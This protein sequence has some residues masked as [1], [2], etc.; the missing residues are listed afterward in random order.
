MSTT[1]VKGNQVEG[2]TNDSIDASAAIASSK[3]AD[4]SNFVKKDGTVQMTGALQMNS[5]KI[6]GVSTPTEDGDAA[7]KQYVDQRAQGLDP[8]ESV[9]L[10]T[11]GDLS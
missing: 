8:K 1:K 10:A 7:N 11:T 5:H 6:T 9:R 3:L 2:I 4:G